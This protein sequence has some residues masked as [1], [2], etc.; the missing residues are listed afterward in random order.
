[1]EFERAINLLETSDATEVP[2]LASTERLGEPRRFLLTKTF[3]ERG[4]STLHLR[5]YPATLPCPPSPHLTPGQIYFFNHPATAL[6][7][8]PISDLYRTV[9]VLSGRSG[10]KY[11]F[12]HE[13]RIDSDVRFLLK[14][15]S[16]PLQ[17]LRKAGVQVFKL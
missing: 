4:C 1:M 16:H 9:R 8:T 17:K 11:Y 13:T 2:V 15:N 6:A 14:N 12:C 5:T 7:T 10:R 3:T